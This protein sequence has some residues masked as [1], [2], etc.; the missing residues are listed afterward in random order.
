MEDRTHYH[1]LAGLLEY[2][3]AGYPQTVTEIYRF[4]DG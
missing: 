3:D 4:V 2:P 1:L